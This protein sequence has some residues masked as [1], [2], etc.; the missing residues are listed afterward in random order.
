MQKSARELVNLKPDVLFTTNGPLLAALHDETK[1]IPIVLVL[2]SDMIYR[3]Y[4]QNAAQP[5][6]NITGFPAFRKI[7]MSIQM[8]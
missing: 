2:V 3:G 7:S 8:G 5:G 1:A 4:V 6:G